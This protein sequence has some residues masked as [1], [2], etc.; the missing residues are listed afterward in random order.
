MAA[1]FALVTFLVGD[2]YQAVFERYVRPTWE[3]YAERHGYDIATLTEPIDVA[4]DLSV[5]SIHWQKLLIGMHPALRGYEKLVWVD[6]DILINH[7]WAPCIASAHRGDGIGVVKPPPPSPALGGAAHGRSVALL[8]LEQLRRRGLSAEPPRDAAVLDDGY[9]AYYR[10]HGLDGPADSMINT[11][12]LVFDPVRHGET[13]AGIYLK[14]P[15][16]YADYEMTP[17]SFELQVRGLDD[18]LDPRFNTPWGNW[19]ATHYP[20]LFDPAFPAAHP[21]V[22]RQCVN[23]AFHN[24]WFLHFAGT[25]RHPV[26][27]QPMT[28]IDPTCP[29]PHERVFPHYRDHWR[30]WIELADSATF[31]ARYAERRAGRPIQVLF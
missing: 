15:E 6:S 2:A 3:P 20:F 18:D 31:E 26:T 27:K 21:E 10:L 28:M 13:L 8:V 17:L 5:K 25:R 11:G 7:R 14:Y 29:D 19:A 23:A 12:V 30:A 1:R 16:D 24:A 22:V 4:C 9:R